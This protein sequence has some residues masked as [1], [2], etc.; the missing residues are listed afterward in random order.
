MYIYGSAPDGEAPINAFP[1]YICKKMLVNCGLNRV[2]CSTAD[3]GTMVFRNEDW[4]RDWQE[5]DI[6]DDEH[7]YGKD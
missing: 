7:Q 1:C 2:V 6:I 4:I 5:R 3:G